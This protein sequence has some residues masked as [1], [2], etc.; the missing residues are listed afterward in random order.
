LW[1]IVENVLSPPFGHRTA[2][3]RAV[4]AYAKISAGRIFRVLTHRKN[5][6]FPHVLCVRYIRASLTKSFPQ[7][8]R[9]LVE[10]HLGKAVLVDNRMALAGVKRAAL[11][12][13]SA[14]GL[15]RDLQACSSGAGI[16]PKSING[17]VSDNKPALT[18]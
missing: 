16:P 8:Q 18:W 2:C 11:F 1:N 14:F 17:R 12:L 3:V 7:R 6:C 15:E 5:W 13:V 10:R 9:E 4:T